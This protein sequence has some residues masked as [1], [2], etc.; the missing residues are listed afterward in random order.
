MDRFEVRKEFEAYVGEE[1]YL[2]FIATVQSENRERGRLKF[3]QEREW[4]KFSLE[5]GVYARDFSDI[6]DIFQYCY[7]HGVEFETDTVPIVYGTR[8]RVSGSVLEHAEKTYPNANTVVY[9]PC[10]HEKEKTRKV[11]FCYKCR[12]TLEIEQANA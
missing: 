8:S 9:G 7:V 11:R 6:W 5:Y 10:W 2:S 3:K 1:R 12:E 4:E